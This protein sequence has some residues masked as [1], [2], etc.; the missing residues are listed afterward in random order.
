M[1]KSDKARDSICNLRSFCIASRKFSVNPTL[2]LKL[3]SA[4]IK[5]AACK[6]RHITIYY[7]GPAGMPDNW[8][9]ALFEFR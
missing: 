2:H 9:G 4:T 1:L 5:G 7:I 3:I 6:Y 8:F